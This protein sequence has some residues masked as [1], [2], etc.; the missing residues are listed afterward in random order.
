MRRG[1]EVKLIRGL[2][3]VD[4]LVDLCVDFSFV[5]FRRSNVA[6]LGASLLLLAPCF[7]SSE[8]NDRMRSRRNRVI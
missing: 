4:R 2:S 6:V 1:V 5:Q 3:G 7:I 8:S